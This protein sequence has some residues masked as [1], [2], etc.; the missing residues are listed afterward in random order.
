MLNQLGL[1]AGAMRRAAPQNSLAWQVLVVAG[2]LLFSIVLPFALSAERLALIAAAVVGVGGVI[3]LVRYP[4]F[5]LF[6]LIPVGL[7]MPSPQLPGGFNV[8]VILLL[9]LVGLWVLQI[10]L[11]KQAAEVVES[12]TI[13]PLMYLLAVAVLAFVVGQLPWFS[14]PTRAPLDAQIGG[15]MIFVL[16]VGAFL[17]AANQ[18]KDLRWLE[19]MT[20]ALILLGGL[21][22]LGWVTPLGSVTSRLFQIAATSNAIF[23]TW[24]VA[25][26]LSQALFNDKLTLFW[27]GVAGGIFLLA[28]YVA[29]VL[30]YDWKSAWLPPLAAIAAMMAA[31]SWRLGVWLT[32]CGYVPAQIVGSQAIASDEYSYSTRLD[33]WIIVLDMLK[34]NP[35]LGFGPANYYWYTPLFRIRGYAVRFNSHN[36][37][38]DILAQVGILGL[39]CV[40]WFFVE[41]GLLGWRLRE[42]VPAGFARS[43]VYGALGGLAG[44]VVSGML[45]DWFLPFTYNIGLNGFRSSVFAWLF[46]G[47]LVAIEQTVRRQKLA[48]EAEPTAVSTPENATPVLS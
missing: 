9:L 2:V 35:I 8:A 32:I 33:A 43:Y 12:R 11:R 40:L 16:A 17:L 7:V 27:R 25:L 45:V 38:L 42:R 4:Q 37:Y 47:G 5:A 31:W 19:R 26:S 1:S 13:R 30:Q 3:L 15:L 39:L 28:L 14:V 24:L 29:F 36:Q 23:W 22:A 20:W 21:F 10:F 34:T 46:L 41:A 6:T 48:E 18:I 44:T